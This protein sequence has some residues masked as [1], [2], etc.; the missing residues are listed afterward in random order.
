M[1]AGEVPCEGRA[2][3]AVWLPCNL[4]PSSSADFSLACTDRWKT[5]WLVP[6]VMSPQGPLGLHQLFT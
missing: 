4:S 5:L 1:V 3:R 2:R 6:A